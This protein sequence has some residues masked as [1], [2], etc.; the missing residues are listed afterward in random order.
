MTK[1]NL[2]RKVLIAK[3]PT[4]DINFEGPIDEVRVYNR[5]LSEDEVVQNMNAEGM[6]VVNPAEKLAF[7]WGKI[8]RR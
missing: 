3:H 7:T 2:P 4:A 6:A 8:K 1:W 5:A